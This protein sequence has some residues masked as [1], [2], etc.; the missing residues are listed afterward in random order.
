MP[1]TL[2]EN[3]GNGHRNM[4]MGRGRKMKITMGIGRMKRSRSQLPL[5]QRP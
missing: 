5:W 2:L 1:N 3:V 4:K